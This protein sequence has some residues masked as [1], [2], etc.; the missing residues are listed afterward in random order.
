M[1]AYCS[2]DALQK[3]MIGVKFDDPTTALATTSIALA[4]SEVDTYL[5]RRYDIATLRALVP[6]PPK[7]MNC[8]ML[9]A[10]GYMWE[11]L[12]RGGKES[13]ARANNLKKSAL[14]NLQLILDGDADLVDATGAVI[15]EAEAEENFRVLCNTTDYHTT[16]NEDDPKDWDVDQDKLDD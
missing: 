15:D 4:E 14:A 3:V 8:T 11:F 9:L 12:S 5:S 2:E 6:P 7:L 16:F 10:A 1:G 13:L